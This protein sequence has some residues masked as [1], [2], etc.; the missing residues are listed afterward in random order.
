MVAKR[1]PHKGLTYKEQVAIARAN[2]ARS[3]EEHR[4]EV[5]RYIAEGGDPEADLDAFIR[6]VFPNGL[7][8][9]LNEWR[10]ERGKPPLD[11]Q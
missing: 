7:L 4:R 9:S 10:A 11:E 3:S 1:N 6:E 2:L 5:E 8:T